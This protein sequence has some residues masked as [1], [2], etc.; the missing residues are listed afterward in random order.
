MKSKRFLLDL[1]GCSVWICLSTPG[2]DIHGIDTESR[3]VNA[4]GTAYAN[5][6]ELNIA[7]SKTGFVNWKAARFFALDQLAG[8]REDSGWNNARLSE[9]PLIIYNAETGEPRYYEFR[10]IRNGAEIGA[11]A[12]V[13]EKTEGAPVQYVL[14]FANEITEPNAR[15]VSLNEGKLI[16][17]GYPGKLL[18]RE[19][20]GGRSIDAATGAVD[21]TEYPIDVRVKEALENAPAELLEKFGLTSQDLI[22]Q[23]IADEVKKEKELAVF[24][25]EVDGLTEKILAMSEEE[26]EAAF[27]ED[28]ARLSVGTDYSS[29]FLLYDWENKSGWHN[30]KSVYCGPDTVAFI[31]L[32]L[33]TRSGYPNIPLKNDSDRLLAFYNAVQQNMGAGPKLY[34]WFN[35]DSL[36][37][38]LRRLTGGRYSI[39]AHWGTL[40]LSHNWDMVNNS[41][42]RNS[43]PAISLRMSSL[44]HVLSSF[45]WD[46]HY[47]TIIGTRKATSY[48]EAKV[49]WWTVKTPY[50]TEGQYR[51]HDNGFDGK[52]WWEG[53]K[54]NHFQAAS[55]RKN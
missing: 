35:G 9:H 32:G 23:Y 24:W 53:P 10:V 8:I 52:T 44:A 27:G 1:S 16:D 19:S 6:D 34:Q 22:D 33:G 21:E 31:M 11:I 25:E 41:I 17:A 30:F 38:G 14:P 13:A 49:L 3:A 18:M 12:C 48:I 26:L 28:A 54:W 50:W 37:G 39:G 47:R 15:A 42:R 40:V 20:N 29:E 4:T 2:C 55:V 46:W 5:E 36:D 7:A 45:S 51:M 43:L